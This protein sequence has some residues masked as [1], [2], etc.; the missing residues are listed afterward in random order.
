MGWVWNN[1]KALG[2][3]PPA[4]DDEVRERWG[5]DMPVE[6]VHA[7]WDSLEYL[8]RASSLVECVNSI[9]RKHARPTGA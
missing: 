5:I 6:G 1:R 2:E 9:L 8:H 4:T 3:K 7:I